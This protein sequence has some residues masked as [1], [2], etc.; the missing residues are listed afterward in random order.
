MQ[1]ALNGYNSI[2]NDAI[3]G[4]RKSILSPRNS[5][6]APFLPIPTSGNSLLKIFK[7]KIDYVDLFICS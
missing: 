4:R 5:H 6:L 7:M 3:Q 1:G 2:L